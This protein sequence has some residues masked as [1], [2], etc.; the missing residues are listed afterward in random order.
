[1]TA[2]R[3][4]ALYTHR[5][6]EQTGEA[7]RGFVERLTGAGIQVLVEPEEAEKHG[8]APVEGLEVVG[9]PQDGDPDLAV[10]MGGD[11]TM[12]AA[13]RT[14]AGADV[15]VFAF[16]FGAVG[17]LATVE[18]ADF[19]DGVRRVLESDYAVRG[20]PALVI[21]P[22]GGKRIGVNDIAFH[23]HPGQR[24]AELAYLVEGE[25]L[26]Q[27][28]C[29]GLVVSTPVGSTGYNLA[30]GGPILAWGARGVVVSFIAP[31]SLTARTLVIGTEDVLTVRNL[32][33]EDPVDVDAD[34]RSACTLEPL[35]DLEVRFVDDQVLLAQCPGRSFYGQLREKF[36]RLAY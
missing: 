29:D 36:G 2:P 3:R 15:P 27:V 1:M 14:F 26:G 10:V 6:P 17:F 8:L 25:M 20:L 12:L 30:N 32:S 9:R 4:V 21:D 16:N 34:G 19:D 23:R 24:V 31:H 35:E 18:R 28:R 22:D 13:L 11:G 7:V 33:E 5:H